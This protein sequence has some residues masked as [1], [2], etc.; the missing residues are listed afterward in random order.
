MY[1]GGVRLPTVQLDAAD[2]LSQG[3][4]GSARV[5]REVAII[6][7]LHRQSQGHRV[8]VS[9]DFFV[10]VLPAVHDYRSYKFQILY[11]VSVSISYVLSETRK[12]VWANVID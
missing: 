3:V 11:N 4:L 12:L 1:R 2:H 10:H 9:H 7:V 6:E 8:R 5:G